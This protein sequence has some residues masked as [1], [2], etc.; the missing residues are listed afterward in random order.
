MLRNNVTLCLCKV[1]SFLSKKHFRIRWKTNFEIC[2]LFECWFFFS[3][4]SS[5]A[6]A[7]FHRFFRA[8]VFFLCFSVIFLAGNYTILISIK[9]SVVDFLFL[10]DLENTNR[11]RTLVSAE[12][13]EL[14]L[15]IG[16]IVLS[17]Y[18]FFT[19][20]SI[21]LKL[22]ISYPNIASR[23]L[24]KMVRVSVSKWTNPNL[25]PNKNWNF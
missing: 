16:L 22:V 21:V 12:S 13:S 14:H 10:T 7:H 4:L 2:Q 18:R 25:N 23:K 19:R 20:V 3:I 5:S 6:V 11:F 8:Y 1:N 17:V 15:F 9:I 24:E